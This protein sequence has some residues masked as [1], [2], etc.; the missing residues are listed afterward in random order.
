[1]Q[2]NAIENNRVR[3]NTIKP[4]SKLEFNEEE[5]LKEIMRT[6]FFVTTLSNG[7]VDFLS[8]ICITPMNA[9][10]SDIE[11]SEVITRVS[12]AL[13]FCFKRIIKDCFCRL[14][15][16]SHEDSL[17]EDELSF[18]SVVHRRCLCFDDKSCSNPASEDMVE[19]TLSSRSNS[20]LVFIDGIASLNWTLWLK[21]CR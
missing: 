2:Y 12:H 4:K 18:F 3:G 5:K 14:L 17:A 16:F 21:V 19:S 8:K 7:T 20:S 10:H 11:S 15:L 6:A 9:C 13:H 1:M